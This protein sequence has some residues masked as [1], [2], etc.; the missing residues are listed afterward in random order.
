MK[1][2]CLT[3]SSSANCTTFRTKLSS[4]WSFKSHAACFTAFSN[5]SSLFR[6]TSREGK[7][8]EIRP[9]KMGLS[10]DTIFGRL[11]SLKALIKTWS[12]GLSGSPLLRAPATTNTDFIALKPQS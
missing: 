2:E 8:S 10:S 5:S 4:G 9:K 12:S 7:R 1:T 3:N 6:G 11:K